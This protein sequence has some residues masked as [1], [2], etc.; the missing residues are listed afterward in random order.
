LDVT[1]LAKPIDG[2]AGNGEHT[3]LSIALKLKNGKR[4]N[5]FASTQNHF[6][7]IY[8]YGSIMGIL[9]TTRFKSICICY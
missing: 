3:H 1:F 6:L 4:I 8:G 7:S 2:V 9:K 5:L